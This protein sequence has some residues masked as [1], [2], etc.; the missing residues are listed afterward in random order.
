M[1]RTLIVEGKMS[2]KVKITVMG[3][4]MALLMSFSLNVAAAAPGKSVN[5][6]QTD[7]SDI[8]FTF[9]EKDGLINRGN[10]SQITAHENDAGVKVNLQL[11]SNMAGKEYQMVFDLP[12]GSNLI[13]PQGDQ[14]D[15]SIL[16]QS[17]TGE[18]IGAVD[19]LT[20]YDTDGNKVQ[21]SVK[22]QGNAVLYTIDN[23]GNSVSYPLSGGITVY[24]DANS[25]STWFQYGH[26]HIRDNGMKTLTLMP[27]SGWHSLDVTTAQLSW[28]WGTVKAKFSGHAYWYNET[29]L[30]DQY[31]CHVVGSFMRPGEEW[32]LEPDRPAV[33][34]VATIQANCNP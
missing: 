10:F 22:L 8:S 31:Y 19:P 20:L 33:G 25:F 15:G 28:S 7:N 23:F 11:L 32:D 5:V 12:E 13:L 24:A 21:V 18:L 14:A 3:L 2:M 4:C 29:G 9:A 30:Y 6:I 16:I 17:S 27:T 34:T 1:M 26:W